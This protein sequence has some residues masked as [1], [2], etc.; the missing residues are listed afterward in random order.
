MRTSILAAALAAFSLTACATETESESWLGT[1]EQ[2]L[3][4]PEFEPLPGNITEGE[5]YVTI[6]LTCLDTECW[7][8]RVEI[9]GTPYDDIVVLT[10]INQM[11]TLMIA[12][13][14]PAT[15][16]ACSSPGWSTSMATSSSVSPR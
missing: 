13:R 16:S 6:R 7:R 4:L 10:E 15:G 3:D 11:P 5:P 14:N 2:N 12:V 8:S 1:T 9:V